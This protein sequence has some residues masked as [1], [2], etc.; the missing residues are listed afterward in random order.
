MKRMV[1]RVKMNG[2]FK[3]SM[4]EEEDMDSIKEEIAAK[5]GDGIFVDGVCVKQ[6]YLSG[7]QVRNWTKRT[8]LMMKGDQH[9]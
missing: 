1:V 7:E 5:Y 8:S 2:V 4:I 9:G 6:G 3:T